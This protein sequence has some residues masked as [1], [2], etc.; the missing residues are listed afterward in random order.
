MSFF[1]FLRPKKSSA[2]AKIRIDD[3]KKAFD[4]PFFFV[5]RSPLCCVSA[6][7][8]IDANGTWNHL[9]GTNSFKK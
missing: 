7:F 2:Y 3:E 8:G 6:Y 4:G 9:N 1:L 5:W